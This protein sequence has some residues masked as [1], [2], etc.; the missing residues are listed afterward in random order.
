MKL[1]AEVFRICED[2]WPK[3]KPFLMQS[4]G[5]DADEVRKAAGEAGLTDAEVGL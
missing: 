3:T 4:L 5:Y 1:Q 2:C